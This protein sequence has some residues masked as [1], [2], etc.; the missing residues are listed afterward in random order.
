[1]TFPILSGITMLATAGVVGSHIAEAANVGNKLGGMSVQSLGYMCAVIL[2]IA[3][4]KVVQYIPEAMKANQDRMDAKDKINQA[5]MDKQAKEHRESIR[6]ISREAREKCEALTK[7]SIK[8]QTAL[9]KVIENL[10][11]TYTKDMKTLSDTV[12]KHIDKSHS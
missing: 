4:V 11:D 9:V 7:G 12:K 6:D 3:L 8:S 2:C 1:M 5:R 10:G